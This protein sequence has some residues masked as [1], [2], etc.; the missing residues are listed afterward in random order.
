MAGPSPAP[1]AADGRR[2]Q[3][4][5]PASVTQTCP[6]HTPDKSRQPQ[7]AGSLAEWSP[8]ERERSGAAAERL[9]TL[10]RLADHGNE[11][12]DQAAGLK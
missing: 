4:V 10:S 2:S 9:L 12:T 8:L 6:L 1:R 5:I 3:R 11:P 7:R